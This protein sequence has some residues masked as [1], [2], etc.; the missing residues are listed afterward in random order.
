MIDEALAKRIDKITEEYLKLELLLLDHG[1][2]IEAL[3][4]IILSFHPSLKA[5][6]Q[7]QLELARTRDAEQRESLNAL[8]GALCKGVSRQSPQLPN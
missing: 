8:L 2:H 3:A 7:E 5:V 1:E 6:F 4:A